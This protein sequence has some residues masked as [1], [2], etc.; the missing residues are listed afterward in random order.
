MNI[1]ENLKDSITVIPHETNSEIPAINLTNNRRISTHLINKHLENF[2]GS[3]EYS[4]LKRTPI[5]AFAQGEID[6]TKI[7]PHEYLGRFLHLLKMFFL[8]TWMVKDNSIDINY[9]YL[10]FITSKGNMHVFSNS[11]TSSI[12]NAKGEQIITD[13][14]E[15]ELIYASSLLKDNI[16]IEHKH[17]PKF[18]NAMFTDR[19]SMANYF[20]QSGRATHDLGIKNIS[21]CS[22]LETLFA[23]GD[24][25]EL[26]HKLSERISK[27]LESDLE[28]RIVLY[29]NIKKI[30]DLRSKIVHGSIYKSNKVEELSNLVGISDEICRRIL[31]LALSKE[32]IFEKNKEELDQYFTELILK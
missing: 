1:I 26:S 2:I 13:F 18:A 8:C 10:Y 31:V 27:Y 16:S 24:T 15:K 21:Y 14:D 32:T 17:V 20:V 28:K 6:E 22:A 30:Y 5:I 4:Y 11:M 29:K 12:F 7:D 19:T 9:G 25:T 3:I 23:N